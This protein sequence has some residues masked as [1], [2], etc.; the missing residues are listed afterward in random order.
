MSMHNQGVTQANCELTVAATEKTSLDS[1]TT[2]AKTLTANIKQVRDVKT[3]EL[4]TLFGVV[5]QDVNTALANELAVFCENANCDYFEVLK[6]LDLNGEGFYPS[7]VEEE[8]KNNAYLLLE[9]ADNINAKLRLPALSRQI[10]EDMIKHAINLTQDALRGCGKTLRR[11]RVAVL[12][13]FNPN[14]ATGAFVKLL[15]LKGAKVNLY[16]PESKGEA[17]ELNSVKSNLN[18]TLE[19][20]DC[21]VILTGERQFSSLN[22]KKI[23]PLTKSPSVILDLAGVYEPEKVKAEGFI[24]RGIGR[25]TG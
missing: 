22:L 11:A 10:N 2:I 8:N 3:A 14:A 20:A 25:G 16:D 23:K 1:A 6:L 7:I 13:K 18:E 5:K 19:G 4:A 24:Y 12:G 17:V 9:C 15:E 21:I